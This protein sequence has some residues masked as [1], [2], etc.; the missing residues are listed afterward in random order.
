MNLSGSIFKQKMHFCADK[1]RSGPACVGRAKVAGF[2]GVLVG[3]P[4]GRDVIPE[5]WICCLLLDQSKKSLAVSAVTPTNCT[6]KS[7]MASPS[8]SA[9]TTTS[10]PDLVNAYQTEFACAVVPEKEKP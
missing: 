7:F 6:E 9:K 3:Q 5:G 8:T 2:A 4:S 1:V 10:V